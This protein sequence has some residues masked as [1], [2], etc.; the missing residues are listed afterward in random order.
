MTSVTLSIVS[1]K[2]IALS[3]CCQ[4]DQQIVVKSGTRKPKLENL[5]LSQWSIAN[6]ANY[7]KLVGEI[8]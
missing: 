6:L 8:G 4:G 5:T 2:K 7:L 1:L 3:F